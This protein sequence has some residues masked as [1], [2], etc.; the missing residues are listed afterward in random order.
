MRIFE[1]ETHKFA[2]IFP[3][4]GDDELENLKEDI[5]EYG[6]LEPIIMY[7]GKILDGRNRYRASKEIGIEPKFEE[8]KGDT[9]LEYVLSLNL[10]RRH[11][12]QS[13]ASVIAL[14]VLPLLEEEAK[15][16]QIRKPIDDS[17]IENLREQDYKANTSSF[18]AG[19]IFNVSD[20]YVQEAK[21]LQKES[22]ELLDRV[23]QGELN[24]SQVKKLKRK[25]K[26]EE[27]KLEIEENIKKNP[28]LDEY[29]VI[30]I[31]PPWAYDREYDP[32]SSRVASPYPEMNFEELKNIKLPTK[33]NC[34]MWLWTTHKFIWEAKELLKEWGFEYKAILVWNKEKMGI[35][36]WLRMQCEFCL[37]AVK[38]NPIWFSTDTRDILNEARTSHSTKPQGFYSIVEKICVGKKL[39]YFA[40]KPREGWDV[41]GDEINK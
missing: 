1:L 5:K 18:K 13:Q 4:I 38:G 19:K 6:L 25:Q 12:T 37:L 29:D 3:M 17:V 39:D 40:R 11:L 21:K 23:K 36:H 32:E 16:R 24:F 2:D 22:P 41:Y 33:E 8:Y 15:K 34:V 14:E 31:D 7:E 26:I 28:L 27:Q 30:V 20:R 9:P 35:G 10:K